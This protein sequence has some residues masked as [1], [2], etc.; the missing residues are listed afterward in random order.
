MIMYASKVGEAYMIIHILRRLK[1]E[2][3]WAIDKWIQVV[4][5][6]LF[7]TV[8]SLNKLENKVV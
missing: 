3:A 4:N 8:M 1:E 7:K 6:I 2:L 5:I